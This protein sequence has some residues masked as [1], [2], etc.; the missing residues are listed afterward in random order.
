MLALFG[1]TTGWE[2]IPLSRFEAELAAQVRIRIVHGP[3]LGCSTAT[4]LDRDCDGYGVAS[5]LGPDADDTDAS[6]NT[7]ATVLA[8]YGT[9]ANYITQ[10]KGFTSTG[11]W[12]LNT[13]TG[14]DSTAVENDVTKPC[15]TYSGCRTKLSAGDTMV[16]RQGII[17]ENNNYSFPTNGTVSNPTMVLAY[18]GEAVTFTHSS[19][20]PNNGYQGFVG[21]PSN[22]ILDG[23]TLTTQL[24]GS[25]VGMGIHTAGTTLV[26]RL[27]IRN[28]EVSW[29]YSDL[30]VI[31]GSDHLLIEGNVIHDAQSEHNIYLG[32]NTSH[33]TVNDGVI[34]QKNL[35]YGAQR[36]NFH[37][38]GRCN[39]CVI[40]SNIM[41]SANQ[42]PGGGNGAITMQQGW[43]DS[44]VRNNV[45]LYTSAYVFL[46]NN[47][48]DPNPT[49]LPYDQNNNLI[50]NNTF[51]KTGR[52]LTGQNLASACASAI[53]VIN[54]STTSKDL[55]NNTYTNN[56]LIEGTAGASGGCSQVVRYKRAQSADTRWNLTDRFRGNI[57]WC[58]QTNCSPL[59]LIQ[60]GGG[61]SGSGVSWANF[62][63]NVLESTGNL[64]TDPLLTHWDATEYDSP[65]LY[66]LTLTGSSP[67]I[68][69]G[70]STGAPSTDLRGVARGLTVDIGAYEYP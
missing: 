52:D 3:S 11:I 4:Y 24:R 36:Q 9:I 59:S 43:H 66:N 27:T 8:R 38:N 51:I 57:L 45:V 40:D 1:A 35:L 54:D 19:G 34:V 10:V 32:N 2:T 23:F 60:P 62:A 17:D 28:L 12:Y 30:F 14:N 16:I 48:D 41:Y 67:A 29:W 53:A 33:P 26:S 20:D 65:A 68:N 69:A 56:I 7:S 15:R 25:G 5:P 22:M 39:Q 58:V 21:Q 18:P 49:I 37:N 61:E 31:Q 70:S 46:I 63:A 64:F 6:V 50:V 55:G 44:I 47:Y 13:S 42:Q